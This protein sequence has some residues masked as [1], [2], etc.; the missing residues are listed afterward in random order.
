MLSRWH[1]QGVQLLLQQLLWQQQY[2][3]SDAVK[4]WA[5]IWNFTHESWSGIPDFCLKLLCLTVPV[6]LLPTT[7]Q[8]PLLDL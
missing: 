3:G 2:R 8:L 6:L 7:V 4:L 5:K 1:V